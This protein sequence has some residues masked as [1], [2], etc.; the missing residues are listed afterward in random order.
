M[1]DNATFADVPTCDILIV[2][3]GPS[4]VALATELEKENISFK[5]VTPGSLNDISME[6]RF[7]KPDASNALWKFNN[8][9]KFDFKINESQGKT[10][11]SF[12]ALSAGGLSNRW[13][14]GI[15]KL[16][17]S[18]IGISSE[19]MAEIESFYPKAYDESGVYFEGGDALDDYLG[20]FPKAKK[21]LNFS[22]NLKIKSLPKTGVTFGRTRQAIFTEHKPEK[23][24]QACINCGGC[25]I[26]C[27]T[28][29][30]YNSK[31]TLIE[32]IAAQKILSNS[33]V[34]K[35]EYENGYYSVLIISDNRPL[36]IKTAKLVLAA[37]SIQTSK[38]IVGLSSTETQKNSPQSFNLVNNPLMRFAVFNPRARKLKGHYPA[39]QVVGRVKVSENQNVMISLVDGVNI[40]TSDLLG[41]VPKGGN[42]TRIILDVLKRYMVFGLA[43]F[44]SDFAKN[45]M[46]WQD[47]DYHI[48]S[49]FTETFGKTKR[50]ISWQLFWIFIRNGFIFVPFLASV[51]QPGRDAHL[52]GGLPMDGD[53]DFACNKDCEVV[54]YPNLFVIDGSWVPRM[55]EKPITLT[56]MANAKRVANILKKRVEAS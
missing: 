16:V 10:F 39:G 46:T 44:P 38:L 45:K 36:R 12:N 55:S 52:G 6:D 30:I 5:L 40:P 27:K 35:I 4:G 43:F 37:G 1:T 33:M 8:S 32:Q 42:V 14:G 18:D 54:G 2:G 11:V 53:G 29:S 34:K 21:L 28:N 17:A 7:V 25:S 51:M 22:P 31:F 50:R 19:T 13:G 23:F 47:Q 41:I 20:V 9:S 49:S 26:H 24:R 48:E 15:S 3:A 56:L